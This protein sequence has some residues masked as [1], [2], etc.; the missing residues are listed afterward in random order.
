[1]NGYPFTPPSQIRPNRFTLIWLVD[2]G[3]VA[4]DVNDFVVPE[5]ST[6]IV[7]VP[8]KQGR[9]PPFPRMAFG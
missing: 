1:V 4:D 6:Q 9:T 8:E 7:K 5:R 3:I 2:P